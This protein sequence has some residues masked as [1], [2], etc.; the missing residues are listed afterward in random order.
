[1]DAFLIAVTVA[2][3]AASTAVDAVG[4]YK[5]LNEHLIRFIYRIKNKSRESKSV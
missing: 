1:M 4:M 5:Q 2:A 3:T